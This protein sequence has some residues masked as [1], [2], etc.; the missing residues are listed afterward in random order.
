MPEAEDC[1]STVLVQGLRNGCFFIEL[2]NEE[3]EI[4]R[5]DLVLNWTEELKRKMRRAV[6]HVTRRRAV[7]AIAIAVFV[8]S[9]FLPTI[10]GPGV[11]VTSLDP[12]LPGWSAFWYSLVM[13]GSMENWLLTILSICSALT[14]VVM[15]VVLK[16]AALDDDVPSRWAW[17]LIVAGILNSWWLL[18]IV[19]GM[20]DQNLAIG[21]YLWWLSFFLVGSASLAIKPAEA[22]HPR[23][24]PGTA[25]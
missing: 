17:C 24:D 4:A 6:N 23:G 9:W 11:P 12:D 7:L 15:I 18:R 16:A 2:R 14:N 19:E 10:H 25:G 20:R 3:D 1:V 8:P 22:R 21:Y 13:A 5:Y